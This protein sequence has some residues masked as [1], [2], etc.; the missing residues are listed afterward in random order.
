MS[1]RDYSYVRG[2]E[3]ARQ[4]KCLRSQTKKKVVRGAAMRYSSSF[5]I[6]GATSL[7]QAG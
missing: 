4:Q 6:N 2:H 3:A 7:Q 5:G 1:W